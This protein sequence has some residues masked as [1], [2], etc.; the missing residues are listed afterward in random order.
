MDTLKVQFTLR[1]YHAWV[2]RRL[3]ERKHEPLAETA[4]YLYT[5]WIDDNR[6]FL[7]RFE[8]TLDDYE[9]AI[10]LRD[11]LKD[12]NRAAGGEEE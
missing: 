11:K 7:K 3:S 5:R 10:E 6:E 2:L 8:L 1:G 12:F 4:N 9:N